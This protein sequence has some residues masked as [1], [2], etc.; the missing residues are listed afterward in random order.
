LGDDA[1]AYHD[2]GVALHRQDLRVEAT[3]AYRRAVELAPE[4]AEA[5]AAL[6]D[7]LIL[8]DDEEEAAQCFRRAAAADSDTVAG[9]LNLAKACMLEKNFSEAETQLRQALACEP[10]NDELMKYLGDA[11]ARQGRFDEAGEAFDRT[12][13]LNPRHVAAHFTIVEARRCTEAD[14]PRLGPMLAAL[15]DAGLG[16]GDRL[17]LRFAIGKLLDDLGDYAEAMRH[18]DMANQRRRAE[19]DR[20]GFSANVD[21]I[22]R[23]FTP[24]FFAAN[25]AFGQDDDARC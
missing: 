6:G 11:L 20:A 2:L 10:Q 22:V 1:A 19:F 23:R 13:E 18:T 24:S 7:L 4:L 5:H 9:R 14:R 21:R 12:L 8:A 15:D 25:S 16:D 17:Q 3:A